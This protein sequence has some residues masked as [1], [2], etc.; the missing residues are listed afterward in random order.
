[1]EKLWDI[2]AI[3]MLGEQ[4]RTGFI[5]LLHYDENVRGPVSL[6]SVLKIKDVEIHA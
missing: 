6:Y 3:V 2:F 5:Y 1:M 4:E